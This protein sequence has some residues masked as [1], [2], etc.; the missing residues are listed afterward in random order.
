MSSSGEYWKKDTRPEG[1][2]LLQALIVGSF[3]GACHIAQC[4]AIAGHK[5]VIDGRYLDLSD[6]RTKREPTFFNRIV[7]GAHG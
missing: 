1:S 5:V 2:V 3:A 4:A 6:S 7:V